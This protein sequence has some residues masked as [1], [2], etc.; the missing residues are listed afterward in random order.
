[1]NRSN[2]RPDTLM[3]DRK[4]DRRNFLRRTAG[5]YIG[6]K[7]DLREPSRL[8][9]LYPPTADLFGERAE[10]LKSA[11]SRHFGMEEN[12]S[13]RTLSHHDERRPLRRMRLSGCTL[14]NEIA[15]GDA[16][17]LGASDLRVRF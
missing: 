14:L 10:G 13:A 8:G 15:H 17:R 12:R 11:T 5:P 7:C 16:E 9:Q 4:P 6:S 1:M 2:Q 3:H